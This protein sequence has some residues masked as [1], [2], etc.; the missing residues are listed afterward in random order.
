MNDVYFKDASLGGIASFDEPGST[1]P[2]IL[3]LT[4]SCKA[5]KVFMD[6]NDTGSGMLFCFT[7]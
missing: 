2:D 6:G 3:D 5:R 4:L 1:S 7:M